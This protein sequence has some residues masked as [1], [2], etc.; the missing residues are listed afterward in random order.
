VLA[1]QPRQGGSPVVLKGRFVAVA[2]KI[3][4]KWLYV[5]DHASNEPPPPA[6][7]PPK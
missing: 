4:G 3:G 7:A 1:L 6:P 5:A 2:K